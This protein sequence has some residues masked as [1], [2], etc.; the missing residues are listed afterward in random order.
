M[1]A[2]PRFK[3][4][5]FRTSIIQVASD[6]SRPVKQAICI[7]LC[8]IVL[9]CFVLCCIVL[10]RVVLHCAVLCCIVLYCSKAFA[11]YYVVLCCIVLY[12][13][14]SC[15]IML[16]CIVL[17]CILLKNVVRLHEYLMSLRYRSCSSILC[18]EEDY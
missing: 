4:I 6:G 14:V 8:Y 9:Y 7:L 2:L 1:M 12:C 13:V 17:Y 3:A 15:C 16:C 5:P 18:G 11:F 10:Y